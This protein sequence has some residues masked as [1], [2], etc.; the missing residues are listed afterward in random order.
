MRQIEALDKSTLRPHKIMV[1]QTGNYTD[2]QSAVGNRSEIGVTQTVGHDFMFHGRF[3][4]PLMVETEFT[5]LFDDD[6]IMQPRWFETAFESLRRNGPNTVVGATGRVAVFTRETGRYAIKRGDGKVRYRHQRYQP[7]PGRNGDHGDL[8]QELEVDFVIHSYCFRSS[9]AR[10]FWA[11]PQYT[12]ANGEDIAF[13]AAL[14]IAAG[15]RAIVPRQVSAEGTCGE[16]AGPWSGDEHAA[17]HKKGH[18]EIRSELL[19]H[20]VSRVT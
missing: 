13:G 10:W 4:P 18:G 12:W 15:V 14:Q 1:W 16:I 11:L 9:L 3:L 8:L 5:C 17:H 2:V 6:T 19:H 7:P 20:W